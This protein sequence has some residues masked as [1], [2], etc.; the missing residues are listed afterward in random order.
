[1]Q[2]GIPWGVHH[3]HHVTST[4][5]T[6]QVALRLLGLLLRSDLSIIWVVAIVGN[7]MVSSEHTQVSQVAHPHSHIPT[8]IN[9]SCIVTSECR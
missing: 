7:Y 5:A 6:T 2:L 9:Y 1:M 4:M 8:N 3:T